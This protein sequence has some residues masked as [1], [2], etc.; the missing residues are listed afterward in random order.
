MPDVKRLKGRSDSMRKIDALENKMLDI[1]E[2]I[3]DSRIA[4]ELIADCE[5]YKALE[6]AVRDEGAFNDTS[7]YG[8]IDKRVQERVECSLKDLVRTGLMEE[9]LMRIL[10]NG[11]DTGRMI[12]V[13]SWPDD[14]K[15]KALADPRVTKKVRAVV[16]VSTDENYHKTLDILREIKEEV[17]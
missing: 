7:A 14:L 15:R 17:E 6:Q 16:T 3:A 1:G 12:S 5:E 13:A 2:K 11:I 9:Y 8:H 4:N 10:I